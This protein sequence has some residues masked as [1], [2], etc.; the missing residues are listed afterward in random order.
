LLDQASQAAI[1]DIDDGADRT[2]FAPRPAAFP[3]PDT[4]TASSVL[5]APSQMP[6]S[7]APQAQSI[8][9]AGGDGGMDSPAP[10]GGAATP[11]QFDNEPAMSP[12]STPVATASLSGGVQS[13]EG[14]GAPGA[15]VIE[16]LQSPSLAIQKTAPP[17]IQVGK[18]TEFQIVVRNTGPVAASDVVVLDDVPRGTRFVNASPEATRTAEGQ[19]MWQLGTLQPGDERVVKI[20][21]LPIAE[22]EVGSVAQ[23][24]FESQASARTICTKPELTVKHTGPQK[25][26]IGETV[27]LDITV[28]NPGT[29]SATNVVLEEDVPEGL[30]HAAGRELERD[31]GTLRPGESRKVALTLTA[32]KPGLIQN[33][34][35]VRGDGNLL[36]Q[37]ALQLEVIAP[38]LEVS[39]D[40]PGKRYLDRPATYAIGVA[41]SGTA[42]AREI[43]LV[44]YLP[45]GM[46]FVSADNQG[47]YEPQNHAVY[48]SLEELPAKQ[49][50]T[51][52]LTLLPLE[53]GDQK[54]SVEGRAELGLQHADEKTVEVASMS[55][56]QFTIADEADPIE[57]GAETTYVITLD[58]SGSGAATDIQLSVALPPQLKAIGGDGPT[59]VVVEGGQLAIDPLG[60]LGAGE[61]AVYKIRVQGLGDGPQRFQVRLLTKET[62][63]PVTKEEVTHVYSDK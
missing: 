43:E 9:A 54:L 39:I 52:E 15:Q 42:S 51:A 31:L 1:N 44:T 48:W 2:G 23:V 38:S 36:V 25:V 11:G 12:P 37:D 47:D 63:V 60:R 50:G 26:L 10:Y 56:L 35:L 61:K 6:N 7:A 28:A 17:E 21:L 14:N 18:E 33:V 49:A 16:G 32:E 22:G 8:Y 40:G 24:L 34:V 5:E 27:E 58:N 45:K 59:S 55:Q 41:N 29:G 46:K 3:N 4:S 62:G 13:F 30:V 19:L 57:V 53:T 20:Q